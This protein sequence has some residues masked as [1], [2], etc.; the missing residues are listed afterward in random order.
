MKR[1]RHGVEHQPVALG[2]AAVDEIC[3]G[4]EQ[5]QHARY[6][7]AATQHHFHPEIGEVEGQQDAG[8]AGELGGAVERAVRAEQQR[9]EGGVRPDPAG[10]GPAASMR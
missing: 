4:G 8:K 10:S 3:P 5:G 1:Q 2:A 7:E 9:H 6:L